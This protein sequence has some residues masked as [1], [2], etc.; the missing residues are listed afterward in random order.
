MAINVFFV[1]HGQWKNTESG[2][3]SIKR[4]L[5]SKNCTQ[6]DLKVTGKTWEETLPCKVEMA[7]SFMLLVAVR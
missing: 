6:Q 2:K 3:W 1:A 4:I 5:P 7:G